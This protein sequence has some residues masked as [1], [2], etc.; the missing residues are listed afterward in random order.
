MFDIAAPL[1]STH[2]AH[3]CRDDILYIL[4]YKKPGRLSS[5]VVLQKLASDHL[6]ILMQIGS[7]NVNSYFATRRTTN[8][9]CF[10]RTLKSTSSIHQPTT[11]EHLDQAVERITR[12][13]NHAMAASTMA[14]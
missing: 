9:P 2:I 1:E 3:N 13:I 8:F 14:K 4:L 6:P 12:D 10:Q 7:K 5:S 11:K